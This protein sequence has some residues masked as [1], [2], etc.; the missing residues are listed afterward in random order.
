MHDKENF[1]MQNQAGKKMTEVLKG[2]WKEKT[3]KKGR[4]IEKFISSVHHLPPPTFFYVLKYGIFTPTCE[5]VYIEI[6]AKFP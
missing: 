2:N 4:E 1:K 3:K 6:N 5:S